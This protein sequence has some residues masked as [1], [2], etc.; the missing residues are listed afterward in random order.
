MQTG[1]IWISLNTGVPLLLSISEIASSSTSKSTS[2]HTIRALATP[3]DKAIATEADSAFCS[4]F[5]SDNELEIY[6]Q[7]MFSI[8]FS[9]F[10]IGDLFTILTCLL[11]TPESF[12]YKHWPAL[13]QTV[14]FSLQN[15]LCCLTLNYV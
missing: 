11:F 10:R 14:V 15:S 8:L 7:R 3:S 13:D 4:Q 5:L 9:F 2:T 6:A 12:F 1:S